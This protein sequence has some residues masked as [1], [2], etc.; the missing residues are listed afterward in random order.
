[1]EVSTG[2]RPV[3]DQFR[4][5]QF[6]NQLDEVEIPTPRDLIGRGKISPMTT[7]AHGP[8][9]AAK[10]EMLKQMNAIMA[11][12]AAGS[13]LDFLPAVTPMMPTMNC[14]MTIPEP[15][16]MRIL[17]R[18]KR[19]TVQ[20]EMGVEQTLTRVVTREMRKGFLIVPREVKKTVPK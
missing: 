7:H 12:T 17:R 4:L 3:I 9:V 20:K 6:Q 16:M 19:S 11:E 2:D 1:M 10:K 18:P 14:M 13:F 15:P 8:Q 5:T